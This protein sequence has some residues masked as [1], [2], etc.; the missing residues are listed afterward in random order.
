MSTVLSRITT[1]LD[2][3]AARWSMNGG[4]FFFAIFLVFSFLSGVQAH[5]LPSVYP[6]T[7]H[8]T[9][10]LLLVVCVPL[11]Y[12]CYARHRDQRFWWWC[13]ITY[14]ATFFIEVLGVATGSIFGAYTYGPTMW[15]QWLGVPLVIALNWTLLILA[16]NQIASHWGK[17]SATLTALL[18]ALLIMIYDYFIEP[19]AIALD[20]WHWAAIDV[21][22]QNY[23]AW[24]IIAF[25]FSWALNYFKIRYQHPLLVVYAAAQLVFFLLLQAFL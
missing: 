24:G 18:A 20:Y 7:R 19:V 4:E 6:L 23:L 14:L 8:I 1:Y 3:L 10:V 12:F 2:R 16:M 22:L 15:M 25:L 9:D 5:L 21:P 17:A 11:L 13:G